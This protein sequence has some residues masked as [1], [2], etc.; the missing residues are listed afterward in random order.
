MYFIT[1]RPL[2]YGKMKKKYFK[3]QF[4]NLNDFRLHKNQ[5][6]PNFGSTYFWKTLGKTLSH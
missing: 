4:Q 5:L 2:D 3:V 1:K 6:H